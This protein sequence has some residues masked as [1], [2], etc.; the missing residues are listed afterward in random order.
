MAK[1]QIP[2]E[3]AHEVGLVFP[4]HLR[5]NQRHVLLDRSTAADLG[6]VLRNVL[7]LE[8]IPAFVGAPVPRLCM[9]NQLFLILG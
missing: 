8:V 6:Q 3:A 4:L 1:V 2:V 9:E 7:D 5:G